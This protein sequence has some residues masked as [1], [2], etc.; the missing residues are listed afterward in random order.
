MSAIESAMRNDLDVTDTK[1]PTAHHR[2]H[3]ARRARN[4]SAGP[5]GSK[6]GRPACSRMAPLQSQVLVTGLCQIRAIMVYQSSTKVEVV[7]RNDIGQNDRERPLAAWAPVGG[8]DPP[9]TGT[10]DGN[11]IPMAAPPDLAPR[12]GESRRRCVP[13]DRAPE[14]RA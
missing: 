13:A 14:R 12:R 7:R 10:A 9:R 1:T 5:I 2:F 8:T 3:S 6:H 11:S 4:E